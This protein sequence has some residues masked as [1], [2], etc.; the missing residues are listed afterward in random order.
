MWIGILIIL[1]ILLSVVIGLVVLY[2]RKKIA[3]LNNQIVKL[4][5]DNQSLE[6]YFYINPNPVIKVDTNGV[7]YYANQA[8][9]R[10]LM[11]WQTALNQKIPSDWLEVMKQVMIS[12]VQQKIEIP[13]PTA[14]YLATIVPVKNEG[15][16]IFAMDITTIKKFEHDLE[17]HSEN[18]A[19][20]KLPNR[21]MFKKNLEKENEGELAVLIV[22]FDDYAQVLY[23]FGQKTANEILIKL[24]QRLKLILDEDDTIARLSENEFGVINKN[25]NVDNAATRYLEPIIQTCMAPYQIEDNELYISVAIGITF[26]PLDGSAPDQLARNAQLALNRAANSSQNY[27]FFQRGMEEQIIKKREITSDLH[28]AVKENQFSLVYQPQ[29]CLQNNK[30]IGCEALVRWNHP[31]K[32]LISPFYF[33][34]VAE[35][36]NLIF[37]ISEF[38]LKEACRQANKW[39][40]LGRS[41]LKVAIN[42]SA[43]QILQTDIIAEI[44]QMIQIYKITPD[45]IAFELTESALIDNKSKAI[46]VMTD[47]KK[48]GF[49]LSIDDFGTGYSS[50]SYLSQF[51]I[52]KIKIDR[53]FIN[54]IKDTQQGHAVTKGI[55]DLGK[56]MSLKCVAEGVETKTQLKYL[57][58]C[59]CDI[60]Q[61][62]IF[63]KPE[64]A[65]T[66]DIY[67]ETDWRHE[68]EKSQSDSPIYVGILHS[69][70]GTMSLSEIAVANA[71]MLAIDEIN[72]AGGV[73]GRPIKAI[74]ADGQSNVDVFAKEAERLITKHKVS[75]I[76]GVW[77][78]NCRKAIIPI[79][80]KYNHLLFYPM[81]YEGLEQSECIIYTGGIPNQIIMPSIKWAI[82]NLGKRFFIVGS[83][84]VGPH[85]NTAITIDQIKY[86]GGEVL[87]VQYKP[88]GTLDF[89]DVVQKIVES[90]PDIIINN[91]NGEASISFYK[92]LRAAGIQSN[93]IPMISFNMAEVEIK[94]LD[95]KQTQ[96]DYFAWNY[97]QTISSE[98]NQRFIRRY[99]D[100]Y[101]YNQPTS[102]TIEAAY[103][104][105]HFWAQAVKDAGTSDIEMVRKALK[106]QQFQGPGGS[107]KIDKNNQHTWKIARIGQVNKN[108]KIDIIWSSV[109][110]I[111]PVPFPSYRT[112]KEWEAYLN[113]L[114]Q[115]WG[116]RW[117][118][119]DSP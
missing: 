41:P 67:F 3:S 44:K 90:Q 77:N 27:A 19:D 42:L 65:E 32:G 114:Y 48:L 63:G 98:H 103:N 40:Q 33:I 66:F 75:A 12:E 73:L 46:K 5:T 57:K 119:P 111:P 15:V 107:V 82:E 96:G 35:E 54:E 6:K 70:T 14:T 69:F 80:K 13:C 16:H 88:L 59:G 9:E 87:D 8:S 26:C 112:R 74:K 11:T 71:T 85:A 25:I 62:Y 116:N 68:I 7:V 58:T 18:D 101:G 99:Q 95:A 72:Q 78:S 47:I 106:G 51:P 60:I 24:S 84:Y 94:G 52:D 105:M 110:P 29:I 104:S 43:Q 31:H 36:S 100:K 81:A 49:E 89:N 79:L 55:I 1:A 86:F 93:N 2:F 109:K 22:R 37:E 53:S 113:G 83:D 118:N 64:P 117:E 61:G 45:W 115:Q 28:K 50:L 102:D 97:F 30:L 10:I 21:I 92:A 91:N 23:T 34:P 76:F 4:T 20:T 39:L 108:G 17:D 56:N 38:V